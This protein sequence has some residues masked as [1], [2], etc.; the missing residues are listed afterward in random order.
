MQTAQTFP[1]AF[2]AIDAGIDWLTCTANQKD[3]RKRLLAQAE[4]ILKTEAAGGVEISPGRIRDY[5]GWKCDGLF[6]GSRRDDDIVV[7]TSS[8]AAAHWK[9]L[10]RE[11]NNVSRLDL[12]VTCWTHGE[13]PHMARFYSQRL[14]RAKRG[15]GRPAEHE[16]RM[17]YPQ[18][19]TLYVNSRKGD[20]YGRVYD[21]AAAHSQGEPRTL[22]R[23]EVELKRRVA[24]HHSSALLGID[25]P[26]SHIETTVANWFKRRGVRPAWSIDESSHLENL[27]TSEEKRDILQWFDSSLSKTI[28]RAIR[29]NGV[30]AVI[31]ALHLSDYVIVKPQRR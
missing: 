19:E 6:V 5:T 7:A 2:T 17:K 14:Q 9:T 15:K 13:Q 26:R 12:Q 24:L 8:R 21:Y 25:D 10:A 30:P 18:G 20:N 28:A 11:A 23:Y 31:E 3:A 22:W 29:S 4:A 27:Q 16:L 1:Y